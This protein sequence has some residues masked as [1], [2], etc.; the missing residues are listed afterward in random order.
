MLLIDF[1]QK[2]SALVFTQHRFSCSPCSQSQYLPRMQ[3]FSD[4]KK[5]RIRVRTS[6]ESANLEKACFSH[7]VTDRISKKGL[8]ALKFTYFFGLILVLPL[9]WQHENKKACFPPLVR[10]RFFRVASPQISEK[11]GSW[12][13]PQTHLFFLVLPLQGAP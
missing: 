11:A 1:H 4:D 6:G 5:L 7:M 13:G 10:S 3:C 9:Q 2:K 8:C 12:Q